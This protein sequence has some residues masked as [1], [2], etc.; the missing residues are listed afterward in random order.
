LYHIY[1][2]KYKG[3]CIH[4]YVDCVYRHEKVDQGRKKRGRKEKKKKKIP[5]TKASAV[6]THSKTTDTS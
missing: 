4:I 2:Y 3:I 5:E 6:D 1:K